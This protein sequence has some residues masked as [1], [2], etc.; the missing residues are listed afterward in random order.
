[1]EDK[2]V[3][4]ELAEKIE[5]LMKEK[6]MSQTALAAQIGVG[7]SFMTK[8]FKYGN[9]ITVARLFEILDALGRD[10]DFPEKKTLLLT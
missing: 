7:D 6:G 4:K 5:V 10:I 9:K 3:Y 2:N 1:M 8:F